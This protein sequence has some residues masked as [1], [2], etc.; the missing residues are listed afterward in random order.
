M[1]VDATLAQPIAV[2]FA[3]LAAP[4]HLGD[5]LTDVQGAPVEVASAPPLDGSAVFGLGLR[6]DGGVRAATGE[7]IAY[8]PPW[9]VCYRLC[10]GEDTHIVRLAC[11]ASAGGTHLRIHQGGTPRPL[12]LDLERLRQALTARGATD[13]SEGRPD[14]RPDGT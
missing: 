1:D 12:A 14:R 11:T 9:L 4:A 8:E 5:W 2:V 10:V 7:L 3:H 13:A 6:A